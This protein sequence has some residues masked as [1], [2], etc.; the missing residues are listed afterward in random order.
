MQREVVVPVNLVFARITCVVEHPFR[1]RCGR[2]RGFRAGPPLAAIRLGIGEFNVI[3]VIKQRS[4]VVTCSLGY[5]GQIISDLRQKEEKENDTS[6]LSICLASLSVIRATSYSSSSSS[7]SSSP[8]SDL[9]DDKIDDASESSTSIGFD[10]FDFLMFRV[11][12][13]FAGGFE[14]MAKM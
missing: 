7:S 1:F 9:R 6:S 13:P 8:S 10:G 5:L 12:L 11:D 3:I 4:C 2:T 14:P